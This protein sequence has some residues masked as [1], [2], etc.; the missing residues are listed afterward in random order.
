M[1][2]A[3]DTSDWAPQGSTAESMVHLGMPPELEQ[4]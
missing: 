4:M 1:A 3:M 2:S